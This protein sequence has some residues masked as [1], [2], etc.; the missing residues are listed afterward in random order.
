[1]GKSKKKESLKDEDDRG[2]PPEY[3]YMD[4]KERAVCGT[5]C[6]CLAMSVMSAVALVYLTVIIYLP[7]QREMNSGIGEVNVM[8]TTVEKR[9]VKGDIEACKWSTCSEWCLSK[10]GGDCTHLFVSVRSN[11]TD[12]D[13]EECEG[14]EDKYC[15]SLDTEVVAK[16]N[17]KEDHKCTRLDRMFRCGKGVCYNITD[18]YACTYDEAAAEPPLDCKKKRN[19]V[20]LDGMFDC[21]DGQCRKINDWKCERRCTDIKTAGKNVIVRAGDHIVS[22]HCQRAV[23][24][25]SG[26]TIWDANEDYSASMGKKNAGQELT[27]FASCT[28]MDRTRLDEITA[29]DYVEVIKASDYVNGS[30]LPAGELFA[31]TNGVTNYTVFTH[32]YAELGFK[33]KLDP[34]SANIPFES[35][36][37]IFNRTKLRVNYEGCVN[38]LREECAVFLSDMGHDGRNETSPSRF[39]CYYAPH[40]SDFVVGR[41]DPNLTRWVF[42]VF[43][44]VPASL[45]VVSCGVL[46]LCSRVL[47]IDNTGHMAFRKCCDGTEIDEYFDVRSIDSYDDVKPDDRG[48]SDL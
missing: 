13:L 21:D 33:H 14:V 42:L 38:T 32:L 48:P 7:S 30:M 34:H 25:K 46:F 36:I 2:G 3:K 19:C 8:C 10:G 17:C 23:D 24:R 41:Y 15:A 27:L 37:M 28:E 29:G 1:M 9:H 39:P 5:L 45:L 43:F 16:R 12:V 11:G 18:V 44:V 31:E 6:I 4:K 26:E 20:E 22:A 35:E 47:N 40:N